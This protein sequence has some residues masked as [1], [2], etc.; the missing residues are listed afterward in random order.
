V[1]PA[2]IL[3]VGGEGIV[4]RVIGRLRGERETEEG[5]VLDTLFYD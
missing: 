5:S 3:I 2:Q 4:E 1:L